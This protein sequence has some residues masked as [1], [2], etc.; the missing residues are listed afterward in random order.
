MLAQRLTAAFAVAVTA[1]AIA[2]GHAYGQLIPAGSVDVTFGGGNGYALTPSQA[3]NGTA[4]VAVAPSGDIFVATGGANFSDTQEV[5]HLLRSARDGGGGLAEIASV[6][7]AVFSDVVVQPDGKVVVAGWVARGFAPSD[8]LAAR[9]HPGGGLDTSFSGDGIFTSQD[10]SG[11][12]FLKISV[13]VAPEGKIVLAGSNYSSS[14]A[15]AVVKRLN[16]DGTEDNTYAANPGADDP[17]ITDVAVQADGRPVAIGSAGAPNQNW[18]AFRLRSDLT[19]DPTFVPPPLDFGTEF[20][21]ANDM[22]ILPDGRIVIGGRQSGS[23]N[24]PVPIVRLLPSGAYDPSF[25]GGGTA[26]IPPVEGGTVSSAAFVNHVAVDPQGRVVVTGTQTDKQLVARLAADGSADPGFVFTPSS[27]PTRFPGD[28]GDVEVLADGKVLFGFRGPTGFGPEPALRSFSAVGIATLL[29]EA[30]FLGK[31]APAESCGGKP[32]TITGTQ[33]RDVIK[34]TREAD[35]IVTLGG[36][37]LIK[38]LKGNDLLC[39][40]PGSDRLVGGDGRDRLYGGAGA[41]RLIGGKGR[42]RLRGGKGRDS[43]RQ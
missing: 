14:P 24:G 32:A 12:Y 43:Q 42:D 21:T 16:A 17:R 3:Y 41:D 39:G 36:P 19:P 15:K 33:D 1:L 6:P 27:V 2:A 20:D 26:P 11:E 29:G 31:G 40:G 8:M 34:G 13:A 18:L 9:F 5:G 38:G 37:D 22:A 35:V 10:A 23:V 25:G 30:S 4:E 28:V 7:D